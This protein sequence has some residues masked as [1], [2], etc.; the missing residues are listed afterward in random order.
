MTVAAA[1]FADPPSDTRP[2]MPPVPGFA[3]TRNRSCAASLVRA[4]LLVLHDRVETLTPGASALISCCFFA[5]GAKASVV[6][7][8]VSPKRSST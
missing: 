7:G 8:T 6:V 5:T 4:P 1:T 3:P 2:R